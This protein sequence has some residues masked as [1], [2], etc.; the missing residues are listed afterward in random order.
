MLFGHA[1]GL[2]D[3]LIDGLAD[4]DSALHLS[5]RYYRNLR[6]VI[7]Q[8]ANQGIMGIHPTSWLLSHGAACALGQLP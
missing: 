1:V 7:T 5:R 4:L 8:I 3:S 6:S 2:T